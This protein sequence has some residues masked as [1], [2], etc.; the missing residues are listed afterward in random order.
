MLQRL[1]SLLVA[2]VVPTLCYL[3]A[4][5]FAYAYFLQ[6][7]FPPVSKLDPTAATY[8]SLMLF[9]FMLPEA[10]KLRLGKLFEFEARVHEIKDVQQFKTDTLATLATYQSMISAISNTVSQN[11][12]VNLPNRAEAY[13]AQR[14]LAAVLKTPSLKSEIENRVEQF[15]AAE[16]NDLNLA[17][18]KLRMELER[19]LR[20]ILG[21]R[22]DLVPGETDE[23]RFLS[24][25]SLFAQF[26]RAHAE[27]EAMSTSFDYV[28]RICNAAVHGQL[29]PAGSAH[30]ALSLGF[31]MLAE[32]KRI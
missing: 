18:A 15:L 28:L 31:Q 5:F 9:L 32:L 2:N 13:E 20:R 30:E 6:V 29:V 12:T 26:V 8:L 7:G 10:K 17:L 14:D 25:R 24:A 3:L 21:K 22:I 27:Y 1:K 23:P 19:E 11:I 4:V 16:S